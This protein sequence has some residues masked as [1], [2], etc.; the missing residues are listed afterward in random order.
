MKPPTIVG[1]CLIV[2]GVAL[3][4]LYFAAGKGSVG[5]AAGVLIG[6]VAVLF[7]TKAGGKGES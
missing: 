2:F 4:V 1:I 3:G 7:A 5:A 6:G